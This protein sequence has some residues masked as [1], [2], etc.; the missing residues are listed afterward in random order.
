MQRMGPLSTRAVLKDMGDPSENHLLKCTA[1]NTNS[2][3]GLVC[4]ST[5]WASVRAFWMWVIPRAW[6]EDR[7]KNMAS[8]L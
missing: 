6:F 8:K 2:M 3:Q 4:G 7:F 5:Q 1:A